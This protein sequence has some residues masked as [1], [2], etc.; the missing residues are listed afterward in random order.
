METIKAF[1]AIAAMIGGAVILL[2]LPYNVSS[3]ITNE[4]RS[5]G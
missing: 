5:S 4:K 1:A 2:A 3:G